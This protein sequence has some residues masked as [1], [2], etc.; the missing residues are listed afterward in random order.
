MGNKKIIYAEAEESKRI[1]REILIALNN[2]PDMPEAISKI[3]YEYLV[4]SVPNMAM[5]VTQGAHITKRYILGGYEGEVDFKVIYRLQPTGASIDGRLKADEELD[6]LA[7][8]A[9]QY[10]RKNGIGIGVVKQVNIEDG[11]T[12]V[13][14]YVNGDEDHQV[15][16][17]ITY[18]VI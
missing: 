13:A 7:A 3:A 4:D 16:M 10:L 9:V 17:K 15:L 12:A 11:A 6:K 14:Q 18:E 8:W 2:Y 5:S 1:N